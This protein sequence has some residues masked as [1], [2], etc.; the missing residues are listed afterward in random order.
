MNAADPVCIKSPQH[1]I[2]NK[3]IED[4]VVFADDK[5]LYRNRKNS[6]TFM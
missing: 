5:I 1:G 6:L 3:K 4:S 2:I